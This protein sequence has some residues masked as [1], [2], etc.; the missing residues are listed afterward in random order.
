[1]GEAV[2]KG[3]VFTVAKTLKEERMNFLLI[4]LG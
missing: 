2:N 3:L 1:M 4:S